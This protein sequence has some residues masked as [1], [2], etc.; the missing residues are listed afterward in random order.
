MVCFCVRCSGVEDTQKELEGEKERERERERG[1]EMKKE[2]TV[3]VEFATALAEM[4]IGAFVR[5]T[6]GVQK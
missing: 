6:I 4:T 2:K 5:V 1:R 3:F